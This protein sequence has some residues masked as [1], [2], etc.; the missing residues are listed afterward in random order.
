MKLKH[1]E[2]VNFSQVNTQLF[3][4]EKIIRVALFLPGMY[5]LQ[6]RAGDFVWHDKMIFVE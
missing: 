6:M 4:T 2:T 3:G 1:W 5:F